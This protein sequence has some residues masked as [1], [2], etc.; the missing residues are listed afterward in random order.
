MSE[1]LKVIL[2]L[3]HFNLKSL[4]VTLKC[5]RRIMEDCQK[6]IFHHQILRKRHIRR[7]FQSKTQINRVNLCN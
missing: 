2:N 3:N 5:P 1:E 6:L 4:D 7:S